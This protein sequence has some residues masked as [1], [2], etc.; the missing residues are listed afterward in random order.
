M[1]DLT[2]QKTK[3]K[4]R[5]GRGLSSG[6][7]KTAGR[8]T[9]GQNSRAGHNIPNRFE[10][11]QTPLSMRLPKLPGFKSHKTKATVISLD[12]ISKYFKNGEVVSVSALIEKKLIVK[13][14][15]LVKVLNSGNLTVKVKLADNIKTSKSIENLFSPLVKETKEEE[16]DIMGTKISKSKVRST[17]DKPKAEKN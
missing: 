11:G 8:G 12:L 16:K 5:V 15:K 6:Q 10:G 3:N 7:G 1:I 2:S 13:S 17:D 9:K 4:K 14:V